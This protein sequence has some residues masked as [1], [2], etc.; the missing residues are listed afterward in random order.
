MIKENILKFWKGIQRKHLSATCIRAYRYLQINR[1]YKA[2][3]FPDAEELEQQRTKC[4]PAEPK[5]SILV[6][7]Y[8]TPLVFLQEMIE[9]VKAQ[10]YGNWELCLADG[11]AEPGKISDYMAAEK[12]PRIR[13]QLL[14][15]NGG[16][17][18]NTN[19]ALEMATGEYVALLDHDDLL[20]PSALFE[21]VKAINETAAEIL[22][23]DEDKCDSENKKL[24]MPHFKPDFNYIYF[25]CNN[26]ICHFFTVRREIAEATGGF[27]SE[28]DGAQDFDFILRCIEKSGKIYHIPK[29]L[30]HWRC[31]A[32]S[33]ALDPESKMYAY[34]NG[35]KVV[36]DHYK[37]K[38]IEA[39]VEVLPETLGYYRSRFV[40]PPLR[41]VTAIQS[42][43]G[44]ALAAVQEHLA[45]KYYIEQKDTAEINNRLKAIHTPFVLLIDGD[46][47]PVQSEEL[48]DML[49]YLIQQNVAAVSPEIVHKHHIQ[50]AG[51]ITGIDHSAVYAFAG[52]Y[53]TDKGY[54]NRA[55]MPQETMLGCGSCILLR[56]DVLQEFGYLDESFSCNAAIA[57]YGLR[58]YTEKGCKTVYDAFV[59]VESKK[60]LVLFENAQEK[61]RF[62]AKWQK[63]LSQNDRNYNVN[64]SQQKNN[65]MLF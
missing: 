3:H 53:K 18:R 19:A 25:M 39:T 15:E 56:M 20:V 13:Y 59:Q 44:E 35:A 55:I 64:L 38:G 62:D 37:R 27:S 31:H 14:N 36:A 33:T 30:Y 40:A 47:E 46:M 26:Y 52:S 1:Q 58:C 12:D 2:Y 11:T 48:E 7:L 34:E 61:N 4:F 10:T 6:P 60:K 9:S 45:E 29:V 43:R 16:I 24:Y 54:F 32:A 22:Y 28:Y 8:K 63:L 65:Y 51:S 5:I 50:Y 23:T 17:S 41:Q 49:G 21:V 42:G 57:E